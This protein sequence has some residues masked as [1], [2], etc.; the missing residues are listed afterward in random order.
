MSEYAAVYKCRLCGKTF[1]NGVA[2][3]G[4]AAGIA[5][6]LTN[7]NSFTQGGVHGSRYAIHNCDDGSLGFSDFQ[8]FKKVGE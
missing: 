7:E 3:T 1:K 5:G 2:S 6:R 4:R 8:G